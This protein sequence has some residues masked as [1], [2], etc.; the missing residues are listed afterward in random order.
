M[1]LNKM[2]L[3]GNVGQNPQINKTQN[4]NKIATFSVATTDTWKD[5]KTGEK[6]SKSEWHKIVVYNENLASLVESY[7]KKGAKLYIEGA[8]QTRKWTDNNGIEKYTTEVVLQG[9]NCR[10]ELVGGNDNNQE[11]EQP[12]AKNKT[13]PKQEDFEE[14]DDFE[15]APF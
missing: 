9:Y 7:V 5:K 2:C 11:N 12:Q 15:N 8:L 4:G 6:K 1:F 14:E 13:K 10:L 3:I